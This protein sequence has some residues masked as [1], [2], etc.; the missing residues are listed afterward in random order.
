M[1]LIFPLKIGGKNIVW[2]TGIIEAVINLPFFILHLVSKN[3]FPK[4]LS[5]KEEEDYICLLKQ[6]KKEAKTKL[7]KH[8]LRLVAHISKKYNFK[9][10]DS[11]DLI[12][13]GTIGLI[14][15]VDTFKP[16][17]GVKLSSYAS[18]CI[19]NE[20]LM[21]LRN[22]SKSSLDLS[23]DEPIDTDKNGNTL[24]LIDTIA[25]DKSIAEEIDVKLDIQKLNRNIMRLLSPRERIILH[26]RYGLN[27][28]KPLPQREVARR[29]KISRS[30]VS[31]LEKK[32]INTLKTSFSD[33]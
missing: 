30:Y 9:N 25:C 10:I 22:M 15:A 7:I 1:D 13:I 26:L 21:Y 28:T 20:I 23:I 14:K 5:K 29:L 31:R 27:G 17:R 11:D 19:D 16:E 4:P 3:S 18:R 2:F 33:L 12:S 8:N 6:G 24:T 32:S